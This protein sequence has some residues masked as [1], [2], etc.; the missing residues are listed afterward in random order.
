L[1]QPEL[2]VGLDDPKREDVG[3]D[4]SPKRRPAIAGS[5]RWG[6]GGGERGLGWRRRKKEEI[7]GGEN[8]SGLGE[9]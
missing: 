7:G 2:L 5:G 8:G 4:G 9:D 6:G 1:C 3:D